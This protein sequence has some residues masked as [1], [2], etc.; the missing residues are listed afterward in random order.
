MCLLSLQRNS[1]ISL[2]NP[3]VINFHLI[4]LFIAQRMYFFVVRHNKFQFAKIYLELK[5]T[6]VSH[7]CTVD[8]AGETK[9][10]IVLIEILQVDMK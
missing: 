8:I 9:K 5:K 2:R 4:F 1:L 3:N 7:V 10:S 6:I